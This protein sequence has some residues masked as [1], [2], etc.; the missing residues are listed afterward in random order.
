MS[1]KL[2]IEFEHA[3]YHVMARGNTRSRIFKTDKDR[4]KFIDYL[5]SLHEKFK[6]KIHAFCLMGNHY[7]LLIETPQGNLSKVMHMLN[8]SYTNY[9]NYH[10]KRTG[11]LFSGRYKAILVEKDS[12]ALAL[13]AYLHLNPVKAKIV[14]SPID[15]E[16]SSYKYFSKDIK[17]PEFME[18]GLILGYFGKEIIISRKK[19][20]DYVEEQL[21]MNIDP[22]ANIKDDI[23]LGSEEYCKWIEENAEKKGWINRPFP[24]PKEK[25]DTLHIEQKIRRFIKKLPKIG[26]MQKRR[27][28]IY[29]LRKKTNKELKEI[30]KEFNISAAGVCMLVKRMR[31]KVEKDDDF[32]ILLQEIENCGENR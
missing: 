7:H 24:S 4:V 9:Y 25:E 15:Y 23:I 8:T 18:T 6:V 12:Y 10:N 5:Q 3:F 11:H 2:R 17:V 19:Y 29:L 13:S 1:R 21:N 16:W 28:L 20:V 14:K 31:K 26:K 32:K 27:L 30:G 22:F